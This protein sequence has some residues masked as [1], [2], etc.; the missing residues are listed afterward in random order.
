MSLPQNI[1]E[2]EIP[3]TIISILS[4][5]GITTTQQILDLTPVQL[6]KIPS[7]TGSMVTSVIKYLR[8]NG[9]DLS[10]G[11]G[12]YKVDVAKLST[13]LNSCPIKIPSPEDQLNDHTLWWERMSE[14]VTAKQQLQNYD[15]AKT[16]I[17]RKFNQLKTNAAAMACHL[18]NNEQIIAEIQQ[19]TPQAIPSNDTLTVLKWIIAIKLKLTSV[20]DARG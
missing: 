1:S 10:A 8:K 17:Q 7:I 12:S 2:Y 16:R 5:N 3:P 20:S 13:T 19:L 9:S 11:D 14:N 18:V 4:Q 6:L 15:I